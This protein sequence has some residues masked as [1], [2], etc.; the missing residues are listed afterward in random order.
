MW[1]KPLG[2]PKMANGKI[3]YYTTAFSQ[4]VWVTGTLAV[5]PLECEG[6]PLQESTWFQMEEHPN[7][8]LLVATQRPRM[9]QNLHQHRV[10]CTQEWPKEKLGTN[11]CP[12]QIRRGD[13][14]RHYFAA[15]L[16]NARSRT[17][18]PSCP[19]WVQ[20]GDH[21]ESP[22]NSGHLVLGSSPH[23]VAGREIWR[24]MF[25]PLATLPSRHRACSGLE[26][27]WT[28]PGT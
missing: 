15:K 18:P 16:G 22:V 5:Q 9:D 11:K 28:A 7:I 10:W 27:T 23:K 24:K 17:S 6:A 13:A 14:Y 3:Q 20:C 26:P 19:E 12:W 8:H 1:G 21:I 4:R 25:W 2:N